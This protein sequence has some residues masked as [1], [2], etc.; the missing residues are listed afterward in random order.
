[1][2]VHIRTIEEKVY[3]TFKVISNSTSVFCRKEKWEEVDSSI[4]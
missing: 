4:L 2:R 1:M 3:S